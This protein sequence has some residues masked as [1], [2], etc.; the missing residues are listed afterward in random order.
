MARHDK[1]IHIA[2]KVQEGEWARTKPFRKKMQLGSLCVLDADGNLRDAKDRAEVFREKLETEIWNPG[3]T[4]EE[5]LDRIPDFLKNVSLGSS[6]IG[7]DHYHRPCTVYETV[8]V[9]RC[10]PWGSSAKPTGIPYEVWRVFADIAHPLCQKKPRF[11]RQWE[12]GEAPSA[13]LDQQFPRHN[14]PLRPQKPRVCSGLSS[15]PRISPGIIWITK[16][17]NRFIYEGQS[18]AL[19]A[20]LEI[21]PGFKKGDPRNTDQYRF[22]AMSCTLGKIIRRFLA[23]RVYQRIIDHVPANYFGFIKGVGTQDALHV[24]RRTIDQFLWSM[25]V[26]LPLTSLDF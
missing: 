20:F 9:M 10:L 17:I 13:H 14:G 11:V 6:H 2:C 5:I 12:D 3:A 8:E 1:R 22:F 16:L 21:V 25:E 19:A 23:G 7:P 4:K 18:S 26:N 15:L 24:I